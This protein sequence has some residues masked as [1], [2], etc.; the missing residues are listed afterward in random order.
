MSGDKQFEGIIQLIN[1][2]K[3]IKLVCSTNHSIGMSLRE[4]G[5]RTWQS[6]NTKRRAIIRTGS[7]IRRLLQSLRLHR[8]DN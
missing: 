8:N 7:F 1:T 6:L 3:P 2:S 5:T 4:R